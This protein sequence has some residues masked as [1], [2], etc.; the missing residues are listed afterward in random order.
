MHKKT[1]VNQCPTHIFHT[2]SNSR[3]GAFSEVNV[4]S[5]QW[6]LHGAESFLSTTIKSQ[7]VKI[8]ITWSISPD[9]TITLDWPIDPTL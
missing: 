9:K 8:V 4:D 1:I 2:K 7:V 5:F 6:T 3:A